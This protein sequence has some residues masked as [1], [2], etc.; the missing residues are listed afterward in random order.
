MHRLLLVDEPGE[1]LAE[2]V[3][4]LAAPGSAAGPDGAAHSSPPGRPPAPYRLGPLLPT[5]P[6]RAVKQLRLE[7]T[8][9]AWSRLGD[10]HGQLLHRRV[11]VQS[12]GRGSAARLWTAELLLPDDQ[13]QVSVPAAE[14]GAVPVV[15]GVAV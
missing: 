11:T 12:S 2:V 13:G 10:G 7:V 4:A 1:H 3:S 9:A 15:D 14:P 8:A 6:G 5:G